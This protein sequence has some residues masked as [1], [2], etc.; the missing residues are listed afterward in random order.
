M[1]TWWGCRY[2]SYSSGCA[3]LAG[4]VRQC[5]PTKLGRGTGHRF[6]RAQR[7]RYP[8]REP[9]FSDSLDDCM[10]RKT[11]RI[12]LTSL[13]LAVAFGGLLYSTLSE[14]TE[15]YKH[16]DEVLANPAQWEG[17]HL[18]L[19]GFAKDVRRARESLDWRFEVH[20]NGE[21]IHAQ[22][23]GIAPDTFKDDSEVVLKGVLQPDG[24]FVVSEDGV[25]A[26]C[27]SKYEAQPGIVSSS[28]T[29]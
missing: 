11:A 3:R 7:P 16:V 21:V 19:H 17:K 6:D 13:V 1:P 20:S 4:K 24:T 23:T 15:Y 10:S 27:P 29:Q 2:T 26:K 14:G 8:E 22:Y 25:M 9:Q 5:A 12:G 18:Q 28:G